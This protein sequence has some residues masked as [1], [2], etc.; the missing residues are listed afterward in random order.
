MLHVDAIL[1]AVTTPLVLALLLTFA[2]RKSASWWQAGSALACGALLSFPLNGVFLAFIPMMLAEGQAKAANSTEAWSSAFLEAALPE[3]IAKGLC[4]LL[5]LLLFRQAAPWCGALVGGLV[6]LGFSLSENLSFALFMPE[7]RVMPGIGH[8]A[9]GITMGYLLQKAL[10]QPSRRPLWI[11]LAFLPT[12]ALHGLFDAGIFLVDA[13]ESTHGVSLDQEDLE[14]DSRLALA[15]LTTFVVE[16]FG[17]VWAIRIMLR[18]RRA[19]R[20][21]NS[22]P[23]VVVQQATR[24]DNHADPCDA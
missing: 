16:I 15:M 8:G 18:V 5:P 11:A 22:P 24:V 20:T 6:G 21:S 4:M 14:F 23:A 2:L 13:Y 7:W 10:E 1:V 19:L 9:W 17:V 3:E 12:I